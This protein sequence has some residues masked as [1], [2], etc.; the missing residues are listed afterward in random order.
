MKW[1]DVTDEAQAD[2]LAN[3]VTRAYLSRLD[4][5]TDKSRDAAIG[6]IEGE[7]DVA[8]VQAAK[9]VGEMRGFMKA[10]YIAEAKK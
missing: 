6:L 9:R 2:W 7:T 8:T 1:N 3:E 4:E 5:E 10:K